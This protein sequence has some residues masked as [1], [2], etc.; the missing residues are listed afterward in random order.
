MK[1]QNAHTVGWAV[2]VDHAINVRTV[3]ETRIG[4]MVNGLCVLNDMVVFR[5]ATDRDVEA[6][7][8]RLQGR[9]P[10]V[11]LVQVRVEERNL[12]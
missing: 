12:Q 2:A 6:E 3:C 7:F 10:A 4:A 5:G 9:N 11:R 1:V 8:L